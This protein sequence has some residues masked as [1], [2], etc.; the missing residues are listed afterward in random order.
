[1]AGN[2]A[3]VRALHTGTESLVELA[4]RIKSGDILLPKFQREFVWNRKQVLELLDSV[5][6]DYPIGSVLLWQSR[7]ELAS[8]RT[9]ANLEVAEPRDDYPRNYL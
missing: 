2:L 4:R 1:M 8:D 7:E 3:S 6:R 9:I 5:A